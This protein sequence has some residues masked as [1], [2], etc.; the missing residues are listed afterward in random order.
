MNKDYRHKVGS[1]SDSDLS[2][3]PVY[4]KNSSGLLYSPFINRRAGSVHTGF[5]V[6]SLLPGGNTEMITNAFEKGLFVLDGNLDLMRGEESYELSKGDFALIPTAVP[7]AWRNSSKS[8]VR[9][10]VVESP[11]PKDPG[12]WQ[13]TWLSGPVIWPEKISKLTLDDPRLSGMG[14]YNVKNQPPSTEI[15]P[16]LN[17]FSMKMLLDNEAGSIHFYMFIINFRDG[18]ICDHHDH[19]FEETYFM[20]EGEVDCVFE[21]QEY[22]LKEG[23]YGWTGVGTQHGFFPKK[24]KPARWLEV[25]VPQPPRRGGQRWYSEWDYVNEILK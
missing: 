20:L 21:G 13:D 4:E 15:S 10:V 3:H 23:D 12:Q 16:Y 18:G 14:N 6:M 24:G 2:P 5:G 17:G 22:T 8:D 7:H 11:Q 1:F 9:W 25:Q 19:P